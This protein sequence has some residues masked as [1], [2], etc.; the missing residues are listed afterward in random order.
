MSSSPCAVNCTVKRH[1]LPFCGLCHSSTLYSTHRLHIP[2]QYN[3]QNAGFWLSSLPRRSNLAN[4]G[5]ARASDALGRSA[6]STQ[7]S[8]SMR[9]RTSA[10]KPSR[11]QGSIENRP[12]WM[13][14]CMACVACSSEIGVVP[15]IRRGCHVNTKWHTLAHEYIENHTTAPQITRLDVT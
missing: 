1:S 8:D 6:G 11:S 3:H 13:F 10:D 14:C 15:S 4:Q 7:S 9:S 12:I 2:S 5:C